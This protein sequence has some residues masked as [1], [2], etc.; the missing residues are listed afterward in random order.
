MLKNSRSTSLY[1][2]TEWRDMSFVDLL[3]LEI[4]KMCRKF[5]IYNNG[6]HFYSAFLCTRCLLKALYNGPFIHTLGG[7]AASHIHTPMVA[8]TGGK[9]GFSVLPK[10][11]LTCRQEE[12]GFEPPTL[13]SLDDLL[14]LLSH[15][16]PYVLSDIFRIICR[17]E[18]VKPFLTGTRLGVSSIMLCFNCWKIADLQAQIA[19]ASGAIWA[20]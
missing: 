9:V 2:A 5:G 18:W 19:P 16:R 4:V 14:Y 15:S 1:R 7:E 17:S 6:L 10:D 13:G 3:F 12:P 11:T 8:T 20:L